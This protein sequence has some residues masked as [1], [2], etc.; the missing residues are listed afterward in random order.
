MKGKWIQTAALATAMIVAM[1]VPVMAFEP[2]KVTC[3]A[4]ANP[5]GGWDFTCR[6]GGQLLNGLGLVSKPVQ[7]INMPGGGGGV[8]YAHVVNERIGE[9]NVL[10]AASR[11]TTTRLAQNQYG[12]FT[13]KD[14]RWIGAIGADY[15]VIAVNA[16]SPF[17]T[18]KDLI[19]SWKKNPKIAAT[20]GGSAVGGQDH[21]KILILAKA[22]GIDPMSVKY[23][24]FDGGG[25]AMTSLLGGFIQVFPGDISEVKPQLEAGKV[26]VLAVLGDERL[27]DDLS[28]IPTAKE[29]GFD[30]KWVVW[31][32]FYMPSG[33]SDDA[34]N[35]WLKALEKM[36]KSKE[37][38]EKRKQNGVAP[39]WSGGKDFEAF[40]NAQVEEIKAL[41]KMVTK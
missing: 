8:A 12:N 20:G 28:S 18:L 16:D 39:F 10:V 6:A 31:R 29:E 5:G 4:P 34:Y 13:A 11:S 17:K 3:I 25:E 23:V 36:E 22:A 2:G 38:A 33:T 35:Y 24:P 7:T 40:V 15:G 1:A 27:P 21:M 9:D 41:T 14:V 26:R 37:W 32:G 30:A 19:E